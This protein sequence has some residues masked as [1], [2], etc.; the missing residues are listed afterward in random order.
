MTWEI[1]DGYYLYRDKLDLK[2]LSPEGARAAEKEIPPGKVKYDEVFEK[3]LRIFRKEASLTASLAGLDGKREVRL[4]AHFQGCADA[5]VCYPPQTEQFTVALPAAAATV[6]PADGGPQGPVSEQGRFAQALESG[7]MIAL[8][9]FFLAGLGLAFTPC[10]FPMIPILSG[11]IVGEGGAG[12][13][14]LRA[15]TLSLAY[16]LGVAGTYA[17]LG[18]IAGATGAAIQAAL[19]NPWVIGAFSAVFVALALSMFGFYDLQLPSSLQTRIQESQQGMGRGSLVGTLVMGVL[20]ALIVGPCVAP[21]LAGALLYIG[22]TGDMVLGGTSLFTMSLGMGV[23]LLVVGTTAGS[24]M[25]R[26]GGWM[27]SVKYVFGVLLLGVAIY[28]VSRI[29]PYAVTLFLWGALLVI[30][31]IYLG[32]LD[33]LEVGVSGW[34]RL[35][36]G[37]GVIL[38]VLGTLELVGSVTGAEDPLNPLEGVTE[39]R[40]VAAGGGEARAEGLEF[41]TVGSLKELRA[42]IDGAAAEGRPVMLDFYADWCVECVR[43][44]RSTFESPQV[45]EV[46]QRHDVMLLQVDVTRQTKAHKKL[47]RHFGIIGPPAIMFFNQQGQELKASRVAG[48]LNPAKFSDHVRQV[49]G[50]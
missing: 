32:A 25:P 8:G 18:V 22:Q 49:F 31:G 2:V 13:T 40:M 36:K 21:P 7:G 5:G 12:M 16:V 20:S 50:S 1:A 29:V 30:S 34:R 3:E 27:N 44:E 45:A 37:A 15:F 24:V 23:P 38:L 14:K 33:R 17:V 6:T 46:L 39:R 35:W 10:V 43:Y 4:E 42:A 41:D 26:A 47:Q 9:I 48:Y 28:L 19:Q 11:I